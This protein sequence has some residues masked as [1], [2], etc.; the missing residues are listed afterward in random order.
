MLANAVVFAFLGLLMVSIPL[1][2]ES[3]CDWTGCGQSCS[4]DAR[5][6]STTSAGCSGFEEKS[7]CCIADPVV[8]ESTGCNHQCQSGLKTLTTTRDGCRGFE[9][10]STC[11]INWPRA[12]CEWTGCGNDCP[13]G[14]TELAKSGD[15]CRGFETKSKCCIRGAL[16]CAYGGCG[17]S[18]PAGT[19]VLAESNCRGFEKKKLCCLKWTPIRWWWNCNKLLFLKYLKEIYISWISINVRVNKVGF[20]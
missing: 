3:R 2:T 17:H 4:N 1:P 14:T 20:S 8:C 7:N 13:S 18:C 16:K 6:I 15:G 11:C 9:T 12:T 5:T 10:K 19:K